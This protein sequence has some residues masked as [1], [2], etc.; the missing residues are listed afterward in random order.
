[1][2]Q[3]IERNAAKETFRRGNLAHFALKHSFALC[4][5][6]CSFLCDLRIHVELKEMGQIIERNTAKETFRRGNLAHFALKHS[7]AL[8]DLLCS[9]LCDLLCS[10]L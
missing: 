7:F 3:I 4:D 5:L 10:F 1:M 9:F 2:G 8:C 6:L